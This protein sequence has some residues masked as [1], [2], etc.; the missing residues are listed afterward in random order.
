MAVPG[1]LVE[2]GVEHVDCHEA[3]AVLDQP[4]GQQARLAEGVLAV[5]GAYLV[6]LGGEIECPATRGDPIKGLVGASVARP[7]ALGDVRQPA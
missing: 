7:A 4:A 6:L 3:H 1:D 5:T 2:D